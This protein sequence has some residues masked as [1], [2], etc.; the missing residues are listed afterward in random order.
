MKKK[1]TIRLSLFLVI[2]LLAICIPAGA[3]YFM[4]QHAFQASLEEKTS[5]VASEKRVAIQ[6]KADSILSA[7]KE[8][9]MAKLSEF[10]HPEKGLRFTPY[11]NID[12]QK[13]LVFSVEDIPGLF[14]EDKVRDWGIYDG[15]GAP[16][17]LT[18]SEYYAKFVYDQDFLAAPQMV[19][20]QIL[21]RGNTLNNFS[22]A[23][24]LGVSMEYYFPEFDP[25][26]EGMDWE[27][28]KLVFEQVGTD[29]YLVGIIH[30]QW[31]I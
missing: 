26:Y 25:Q 3:V 17:D 4:Q 28:L 6:E 11:A 2:V 19:F 31:T 8:K 18:F 21:Q 9:N 30:E 15:S 20:D 22:E 14:D 24:P 23:Y 27:S 1:I 10:V 13:D 7:L 16:I 5:E 12:T 29:W